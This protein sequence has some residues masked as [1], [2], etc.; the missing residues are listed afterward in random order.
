MKRY[1]GVYM[2]RI[3]PER[4][5]DRTKSDII[6][7]IES[8]KLQPFL[9][10]VDTLIA[11]AVEPRPRIPS[12]VKARVAESIVILESKT[13]HISRLQYAWRWINGSLL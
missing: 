4:L 1:H 8:G 13:E 10:A 3:M 2:P 5:T 12:T 6:R 7:D 11:P 9:I